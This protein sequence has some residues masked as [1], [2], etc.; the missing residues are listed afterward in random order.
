VTDS[1]EQRWPPW[2]GPVALIGGLLAGVIGGVFAV[3]LV[4]GGV[5][6]GSSLSPASTDIATMIQDLGFVGAAVFLAAQVA[7]VRPSQFGLVAPASVWRA[8]GIL[9]A[10][11]VLFIVVSDVYFTLLHAS[12]QEKE[13][14]KEIGGNAGTL[15]I[16]AVCALTTVVAPICEE[17]LFRGFIF[18]SLSN[19]RG[20]WPA[21]LITGALFGV[22]HGLSAP[23]VDLAPLAF[24]GF[25]LCIVYWRSG[26]LYPCIALHVVNNAIALSSDEGW[27]AG[28]TVALLLGSAALVALL[29]A[30]VRL[31]S[32]RW[33]P[34]SD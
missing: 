28:R 25:V 15:G 17:L 3:L 5:S 30:C 26:S 6:R 29:L 20:P 23:L 8:V 18:R 16:L 27:S 9:I 14:V 7:P 1:G 2:Y 31:A 13:F 21:A 10:G 32:E 24:L 12:G 11:A 33:M 19:W 34:V 22:V 4:Q